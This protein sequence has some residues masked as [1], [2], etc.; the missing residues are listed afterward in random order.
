MQTRSVLDAAALPESP[1]IGSMWIGGKASEGS[2]EWL[3]ST[4]PATGRVVGKVP[5][6]GAAD[7]DQAVE[8]AE[9]AQASWKDLPVAERAGALNRLADALA[10]RE[11]DLLTLEV[12]D[13]G[14]YIT[15]MGLPFPAARIGSA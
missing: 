13:S 10:A 4:N 3:E 12:A 7:V 2:G 11:D 1:Y 6:G 5:R 9:L 15:G 14:H 8:A